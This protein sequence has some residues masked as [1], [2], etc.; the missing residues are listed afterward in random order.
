[1]AEACQTPHTLD[2]GSVYSGEEEVQP[3]AG[4]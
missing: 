2:G 1:M 3:E 4:T